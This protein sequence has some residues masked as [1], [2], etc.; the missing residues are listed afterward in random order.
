MWHIAS[1]LVVLPV[2]KTQ[3]SLLVLFLPYH[4]HQQHW[5]CDWPHLTSSNRHSNFS[6]AKFVHEAFISNKEIVKGRAEKWESHC[7]LK[8]RERFTPGMLFPSK[9]LETVLASIN[10]GWLFCSLEKDT[11]GNSRPGQPYPPC[12]W[13]PELPSLAVAQSTAT[14]TGRKTMHVSKKGL[15]QPLCEAA[16]QANTHRMQGGRLPRCT[17]I[18]F[19]V[20]VTAPQESAVRNWTETDFSHKQWGFFSFYLFNKTRRNQ[21]T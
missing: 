15:V 21:G 16:K 12:S 20:E 17:F 4:H 13:F 11:S 6:G 2:N 7:E 5:A 1:N 10:R 8:P 18:A 9:A 14:E 19:F 3:S